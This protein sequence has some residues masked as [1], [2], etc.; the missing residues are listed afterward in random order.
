MGNVGFGFSVLLIH[1]N[2]FD[3]FVFI[4]RFKGDALNL[5]PVDGLFLGEEFVL[6]RVLYSNI[7]TKS[8]KTFKKSIF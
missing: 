7:S 6:V 3:M 4:T 1:Q 5:F 2:S 8:I